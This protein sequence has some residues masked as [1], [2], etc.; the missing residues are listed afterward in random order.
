MANFK[1]ETFT[2]AGKPFKVAKMGGMTAVKMWPRLVRILSGALEK[3]PRGVGSDLLA[4]VA[5]GDK[6]MGM[7]V[8]L[9]ELGGF[10]GVLEEFC[11]R[12]PEEEV[13]LWC[14]RLFEGGP[15]DRPPALYGGTPILDAMEAGDIDSDAVWEAIQCALKVNYSAFRKGLAGL[16]A[17]GQAATA[18]EKAPAAESTSAASTT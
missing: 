13:E 17:A 16:L 6:G 14:Q 7:T 9:G 2:V 18:T 10:A 1:P 8:L 11:K 5:D 12:L 15:G 4:A 3:V